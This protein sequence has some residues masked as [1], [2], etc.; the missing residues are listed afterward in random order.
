M[1][2]FG[3]ADDVTLLAPTRYGLQTMLKICEE[4]ATSHSMLFSTDPSPAKSKTKCMFFSTSRT[5]DQIKN[6]RLNGDMLPWVDTAKH[7]GNHLSNKIDYST[8]SPDTKT[9]LLCKRAILFDKIHQV[10]QQFGY[11]DPSLKSK[12]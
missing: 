1:G 11:Y 9:D 3:Y 6:V 2:A 5:S 12:S 7:L 8:C 10:Q 4:F